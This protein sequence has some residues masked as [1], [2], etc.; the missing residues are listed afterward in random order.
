MD[1]VEQLAIIKQQLDQGIVPSPVTV[2]ILLSWFSAYRRGWYVVQQINEWLDYYEIETT[3][4]FEHAYIDEEI[5]F[6]KKAFIIPAENATSNSS[7]TTA[8]TTLELSETNKVKDIENIASYNDP[9][10]RIGKLEAANKNLIFVN[11]DSDLSEAITKMLTYDYSQLPVMQQPRRGLKGVISWRSI[12]IKLSAGKT[13]SKVRDFMEASF[14]LISSDVSL[15]KVIPTIIEHDYILVENSNKEISGIITASDLSLQFQQLSEP[16]L[17]VSEIENHLR[18]IL[19]KLPGEDI[20]NAKDGKDTERIIDGVSDLT[21]GE[22]LRLF[23]NP[24]IWAKLNLHIDRKT[25]CD[26]LEQI[27]DIRNNIMHF[28]PDGLDQESIETLRRVARLLQT[29]KGIE[30]L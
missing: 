17:L 10:Y 28:D 26:H 20:R 24:S 1:E 11:P 30:A 22:Y 21:F 8:T 4:Y 14:Q 7:T 2:R 16:F 5:T 19:V 29:L 25:F 12:G 18:N 27:K 23:Q 13:T 15:F 6:K 3:P 9:T